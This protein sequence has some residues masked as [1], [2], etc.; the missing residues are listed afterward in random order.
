MKET[1]DWSPL[2]EPRLLLIGDNP[3]LQWSDEIIDYAMFLDY[4][5]RERPYDLGERSRYAQ[6][7]ATFEM[8]EQIS[9]GRYKPEDVY[10]TDFSKELLERPPKGKKILLPPNDA[11]R[12]A[13]R[14]RG[15]LR[16]NPSIEMVYVISSQVAYLLAYAGFFEAPQGFVTGASARN[17]GVQ[18]EPPFYQPVDPNAFAE[19]C[20]K[21]FEVTGFQGISVMPIVPLNDFPLQGANLQKYGAAL[22][23]ICLR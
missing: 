16:D 5:F 13:E 10:G 6:A 14:V 1:K 17:K 21:V 18:N 22:D 19:V 8:V 23:A 7:K 12:Q 11:A 20:F 4:Y 2:M 3:T 9:G 15:I